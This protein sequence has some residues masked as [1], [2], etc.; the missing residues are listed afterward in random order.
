M[1]PERLLEELNQLLAGGL[2]QVTH[3]RYFGLFNPSVRPICALAWRFPGWDEQGLTALG[4]RP[5][6]Y[7]SADAHHRFVKAARMAGLGTAAVREV[8][9]DAARRLDLAALELKLA[10]A[11]RAESAS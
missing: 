3:P 10:E 2:V 5:A 4:L 6:I 8:P 1:A 7:L 11:C 9:V